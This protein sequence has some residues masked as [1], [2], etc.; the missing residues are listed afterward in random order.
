MGQDEGGSL[1]GEALA[2]RALPDE[3]GLKQPE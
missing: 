3:L 1:G 2:L